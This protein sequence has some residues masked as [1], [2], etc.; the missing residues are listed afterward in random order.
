MSSL[1]TKRCGMSIAA[2]KSRRIMLISQLNEVCFFAMQVIVKLCQID[3]NLVTVEMLQNPHNL[4]DIR[5]AIVSTRD[6][7]EQLLKF[8]YA[9]QNKFQHVQFLIATLAS[10]NVELM[11]LH[12][13]VKATNGAFV[14]DPISK[15]FHH[16]LKH[17][18]IAPIV[19]VDDDLGG[20]NFQRLCRSVESF[21]DNLL[22]LTD[23]N[24]LSVQALQRREI[25]Q[26]VEEEEE[27]AD[28]KRAKP[29]SH[30]RFNLD[31]MSAAIP[32][33]PKRETKQIRVD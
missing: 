6:N 8:Q 15:L 16:L 7:S 22:D 32:V 5:K 29:K 30:S 12:D 18:Y 33:P 13:I 25:A 14:T 19:L 17:A 31:E 23:P 27:E 1:S 26:E 10:T 11:Q 4:K 9:L 3:V 2:L 21:A 20:S 24:Y 28:A